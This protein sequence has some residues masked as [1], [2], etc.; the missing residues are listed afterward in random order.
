MAF[1]SEKERWTIFLVYFNLKN[2]RM[3]KLVQEYVD[4]Y[5]FSLWS[6]T[7]FSEH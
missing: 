2:Y 3:L 7:D 5:Y 6:K 1:C 4:F